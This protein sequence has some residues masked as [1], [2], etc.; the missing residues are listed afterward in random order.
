MKSSLYFYFS[1]ISFVL[2]LAYLCFYDSYHL[3]AFLGIR[4]RSSPQFKNNLIIGNLVCI[5]FTV[6]I[7]FQINKSLKSNTP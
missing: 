3:E 4:P 2:F 1:A 7:L 5:N 6:S